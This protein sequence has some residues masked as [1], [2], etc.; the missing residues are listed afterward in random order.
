VTMVR[1]DA[2][3]AAGRPPAVVPAAE[4]RQ[5]APA[6]GGFAALLALVMDPGLQTGHFAGESSAPVGERAS[7]G[8]ATVQQE[9][10][11][12][13]ARA[14]TE[15]MSP[16]VWPA[17]GLPRPGEAGPEW[18][19]PPGNFPPAGV[20]GE[21]TATAGGEPAPWSPAPRIPASRGPA[22]WAAAVE[23][24]PPAPAPQAVL[25]GAIEQLRID[26]G[27]DPNGKTVGS[28]PPA[29]EGGLPSLKPVSAGAR[30]A[31]PVSPAGGGADAAGGGLPDAGARA[32]TV[33]A[34]PEVPA[35]SLGRAPQGAPQ[36]AAEDQPAEGVRRGRVPEDSDPVKPSAPAT[37][38][39]PAPTGEARG[40]APAAPAASPAQ[41]ATASPFPMQT[42]DL[43]EKPVS[44]EQVMDLV[45]ESLRDTPDGEYAITLRLYP[46]HLG[47]VRLQVQ[48][49]GREVR[50]RFEVTTPEARQILEQRGEQLREGLHNAGFTLSGFTVSTG[51]GARQ[52]QERWDLEEWLWQGRPE[53]PAVK[54]KPA[55][56]SGRRPAQAKHAGILDRLA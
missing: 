17:G 4:K 48:V 30:G 20:S 47:E 35:A 16:A 52:S 46:E 1:L 39:G 43:T 51:G 38:L 26:H 15:T 8:I 7:S 42:Q 14:R 5:D 6:E 11:L 31:G 34:Q 56:A 3:G 44:P 18:N 22:P 23:G 50:T 12:P 33:A 25:P 37:L 13:A 54:A 24:V 27:F 21:A 29:E 40:G 45:V 28:A 41:E 9:V 32:A 36:G 53:A 19:L 10:S 2:P 49:A 55:A